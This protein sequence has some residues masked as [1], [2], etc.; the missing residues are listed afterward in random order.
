[1]RKVRR[2]FGGFCISS[3]EFKPHFF[4]KDDG[5]FLFGS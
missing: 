5:A 2:K 1:M 3:G 4:N